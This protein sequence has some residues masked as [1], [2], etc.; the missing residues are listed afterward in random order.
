MKVIEHIILK[1]VGDW[2]K[3]KFDVYKRREVSTS[4]LESD[5]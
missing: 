1:Q 4:I 2:R 5:S 3:R